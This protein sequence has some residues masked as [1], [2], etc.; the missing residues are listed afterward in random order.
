MRNF[1]TISKLGHSKR[2]HSLAPSSFFPSSFL[3]IVSGTGHFVNNLPVS[4]CLLICIF[5]V[6]Q[7]FWTKQIKSEMVIYIRDSRC[8]PQLRLGKVKF[9][10]LFVNKNS[11]VEPKESEEEKNGK[12]WFRDCE[13][14][15]VLQTKVWKW[16]YLCVNS[17]DFTLL[18]NRMEEAMK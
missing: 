17:E 13:I 1:C 7:C 18:V 14:L 10:V 11:L 2:D 8:P 5:S 3:S 6:P 9:S 12:I 4:S 15:D 16:G